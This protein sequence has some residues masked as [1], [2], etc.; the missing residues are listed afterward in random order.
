MVAIFSDSSVTILFMNP[1]SMWPSIWR[2]GAK[3]TLE[4][5]IL[6]LLLHNIFV[7]LMIE[8]TFNIITRQASSNNL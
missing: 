2:V 3:V 6:G 4:T 5:L 8:L 1:E 7:L